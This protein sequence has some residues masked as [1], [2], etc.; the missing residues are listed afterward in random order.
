MVATVALVAAV[1]AIVMT[2]EVEEVGL[3]GC[4]EAEVEGTEGGRVAEL[5]DPRCCR[6]QSEGSCTRGR[7][8]EGT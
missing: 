3:E 7:H 2:V 4:R 5:V 1:A 8:E 6:H